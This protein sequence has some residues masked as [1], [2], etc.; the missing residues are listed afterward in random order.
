MRRDDEPGAADARGEGGRGARGKQEVPIDRIGAESPCRGNRPCRQGCEL[1][2]GA[3][4]VVDDRALELVP[5]GLQ[6]NR[7]LLHEDAEIRSH[8]TRKHLR[9][10][11]NSHF[12]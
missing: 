9:Y 6:L 10:Q 1:E 7:D 4:P 2:R 8:G 3:A 5:L 11:E 12:C